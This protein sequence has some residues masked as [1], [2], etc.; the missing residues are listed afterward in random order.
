MLSL[1]KAFKERGNLLFGAFLILV[2]LILGI[3]MALDTPDIKI[4]E[5]RCGDGTPYE[6]CSSDEPYF[7]SEQ[8]LI[9]NASLCGCPDSENF[10]FS[11][12]GGFCISEYHTIP[13][14][15]TLNYYLDGEDKAANLSVFKGV[16]EYVSELQR[17]IS[18]PSEKNVSRLDFKIKALNDSL[19]RET[20][21]PLVK[22]IQNLAPRSRVDQARIAISMV[23]SIP[24][25]FS[26]ESVS[27]FGTELN[28]SRY[29]Y[30]VLYNH[31]GI[32]GEKS[33]LLALILKELGYKTSIFYF[34]EENHEAVGIGCPT[35]ES[36]GGTG[37]CFI[38]TSGPA[39]LSDSR[40]NYVG[41]VK[42]ESTPEVLE[43]S[44]GISLPRGLEEYRDAKDLQDIRE[45]NF[46]GFLKQ[47][48]KNDLEEKY[49]LAERYNLK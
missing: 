40:I 1:K 36:L 24:Y 32:C 11:K 3:F 21:L 43:I 7:C 33:Q 39:I 38:E 9:E 25:G 8:V 10:N 48:L 4:L 6:E 14:N 15:I 45:R 20:I 30:E 19:Q 41:E 12:E 44:E 18:V 47:G 5:N 2:F 49:N 16:N 42:L 17:G 29:P 22:K 31:E 26:N 28:Y 34:Q 35:K 23:Q 37:Y 27:L 46:W 13:K